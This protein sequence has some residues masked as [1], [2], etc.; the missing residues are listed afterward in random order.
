MRSPRIFFWA[1]TLCVTAAGWWSVSSRTQEGASAAL[2]PGSGVPG[3]PAVSREAVV[4][5]R[6]PSPSTAGRTLF[7]FVDPADADALTA[8]QPA[9]AARVSYVQVDRALVEG[10][11]SPFWQKQGRLE[12]RLPDGRPLAIRLASSEMLG[13]NRFTSTGD[14]E[15]V[16]GSRVVLAYN[17]G[18][19]SGSI[20]TAERTYALRP[21]TETLTQFYEVD[22]AKVGTCGGALKPLVDPQVIA[23][24]AAWKQAGGDRAGAPSALAATA[25]AAEGPMLAE[26]HVLM[27][28]TQAVKPTLSAASRLAAMQ[29]ECDAAIARVNTAFAASQ[30]TARVRLV[31]VVQ[32]QYDESVSSDTQVLN[33]ALTALQKPADGKL[34]ELHALRDSVGADV[35]CLILNRATTDGTIGLGYIMDSPSIVDGTFPAYNEQYAF[36]AVQYAWVAGSDVVAHELGHIFGCAHAREDFNNGTGGAFSYSYGYRFW[37]KDGRQYRDIMGYGSPKLGLFSNPN[38]VAPA[39]VSVPTGAALGQPDEANAALTIEKTSFEVATYRLQRQSAPDGSLIN[40]STRAHVGTE[41]QVLIAGFVVDGI[42]PKRVLVRAA[43]PALTFYGVSNVLENP[44]YELRRIDPQTG[45]ST[46]EAD[47]DDWGVQRSGLL[48]SDVARIASD[49]GAFAFA[50][51]SRDAASVLSLA[52][53]QY[54]AIVSGVDATTGSA[55]VE[56]YDVDRANNKV[57]NISTRGYADKGKEMFGGFVVQG[58]AGRTKRVLIKV[59]GPTLAKFGVTGEMFDPFLSLHNAAGEKLHANDDWS[60]GTTDGAPSVDND[61]KPLVKTY[62]EKEIHATGKAPTNRREPAI[63]VDLVPGSYTVIVKPFERDDPTDPQ[64]PE[65]GVALVEVYEIQ[66]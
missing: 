29:S 15:G 61:F 4:G 18:Y 28:F 8:A 27:A 21:A 5:L 19:L 17:E 30:I 11:N 12:L 55:L 49:V 48:A 32:T 25:A 44:K 36:A 1:A 33:D 60:T 62:S 65:P 63:L 66:P 46:W 13:A 38:V 41:A 24:A 43:G 58:E 31:Q 34:D 39:P 14:V 52:P 2:V 26:V 37:G 56:V 59:L 57:V 51:D 45:L 40:V 54:T 64:L 3:L 23:R 50:P 47:N 22:P 7:T 10:K 35:V 53:G 16:P 9:P 6:S 42:Q 20:E